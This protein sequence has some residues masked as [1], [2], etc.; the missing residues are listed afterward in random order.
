MA[1][2][3][4]PT[5]RPR[6]RTS[7]PYR[8]HQDAPRCPSGGRYTIGS[9]SETPWCTRWLDGHLLPSFSILIVIGFSFLLEPNVDQDR[10]RARA[11]REPREASRARTHLMRAA[12]PPLRLIATNA[13]RGL[14]AARQY[15][16]RRRGWSN[17]SSSA[18]AW[19]LAPGSDPACGD[20][21]SLRGALRVPSAVT[22]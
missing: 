22:G 1:P 9:M 8:L 2:A 11:R 6:T 4:P 3:L 19:T 15:Y 21:R 5:S 20:G 16:P 18:L 17:A 14:Q 12:A 7:T 10:I 13:R